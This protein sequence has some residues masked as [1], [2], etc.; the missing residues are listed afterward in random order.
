MK[1]KE[2]NRIVFG[3]GVKGEGKGIR[4]RFF[5]VVVMEEGVMVGLGD[6]RG[7]NGRLWVM[8]RVL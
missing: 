8:G 6:G 3:V 5:C 4:V 2:E 1:R 7:S